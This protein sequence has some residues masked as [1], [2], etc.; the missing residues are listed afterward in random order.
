MRARYMLLPPP[1]PCPCA[2]WMHQPLLP[3][4]VTSSLTHR[5][6]RRAWVSSF[7]HLVGAREH[8]R[9]FEAERLCGR[10]VDDEIEFGRLLDRE[11]G[12]F[13]PPQNLVNKVS[14]SSEQIREVCPTL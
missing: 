2:R 13:R 14:G 1:R 9:H 4:R 6:K 8:R 7:D 5:N 10:N 3:T 11:V 12:R